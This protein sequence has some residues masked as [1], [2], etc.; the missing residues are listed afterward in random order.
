MADPLTPSPAEDIA[1]RIGMAVGPLLFLMTLVAPLPPVEGLVPV[2]NVRVTLG[3]TLWMAAWWMTEAL[4]LSATS[5]LPLVVLPIAGVLPAGTVAAQYFSDITALFLGGFC[6]AL[7]MQ[8][9]GLHRRVALHVLRIMGT[10]P[11]R[12][13]LGFL[14]SAALLSMWV[15]NTATTL[16]LLPVVLT[17]VNESLP[18]EGRSGPASRF[19]TACLL[20]VAFGASLGGVGTILGTPPNAY[21]QQYYNQRYAAEI[22][23]GTQTGIT[24]GRWMVVGV[25]L[26]L[27]LVP[28]SWL[29]LTRVS[30]RVP[31]VLPELAEDVLQRLQ[32]EGKPT[33]AEWLVMGVFLS[34]ALAWITHAPIE[35]GGWILPLTGWDA[36]LAFGTNS[37]F[38]TDGT[39]AIT[40]ALLLFLLPDLKTRN[41]RL[42]TWDLAANHLP[43]GALLLFGGGLALAHSF[44]ASG[45][46]G[47]LQAT[48]GTLDTV[49]IWLLILVII[50][51]VAMLS[52]LASNTAAA[53]MVIPV[54]ASLAGALGVEPLPLLM[55]AALGA[56]CGYALPVATPPNTIVYATGAVSIPNML[57]AGA[58]LDLVAIA[59]MYGAVMG[60]VRGAF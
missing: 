34:T 37:S 55:A 47:Y 60:I 16:M 15:S 54:L 57:R 39:I 29:L 3:L 19:A 20:A 27:I 43:W 21:L 53:A 22:A 35:L 50:I 49:P 38:V 26:V 17:V 4:P 1:R 13:V 40:A 42:L 33:M 36:R 41:D 46:N 2:A 5:L 30:P 10:R 58:L 48:F 8:K 45:L 51:L 9:A 32:P 56:S 59:C 28:A 12:L 52:E 7:A 25:P 44:E 6:L 24:F 11:R 14:A 23:A 31:A 18:L